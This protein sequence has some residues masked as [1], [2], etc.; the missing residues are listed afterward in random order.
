MIWHGPAERRSSLKIRRVA[1]Q[2]LGRQ[3]Y[4]LSRCGSFVAGFALQTC[5]RAHQWKPIEVILN[6]LYG[7]IPAADRVA[8]LAVGAKLPS[9]NVGVAV[10]AF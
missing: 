4:E 6:G 5:M 7:N 10:R 9:M 8:L 1:G 2:A 3:P